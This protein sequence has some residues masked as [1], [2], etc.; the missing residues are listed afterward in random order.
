M[1]IPTS[2]SLVSEKQNEKHLLKEERGMKMKGQNHFT[3]RSFNR[4]KEEW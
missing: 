1:E 4:F 3:N 2:I